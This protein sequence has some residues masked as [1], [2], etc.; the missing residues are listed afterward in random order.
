LALAEQARGQAAEAKALRERFTK[1]A[2][3]SSKDDPKRTN[4]DR[5]TWLD[6]LEL[7]LLLKE[8]DARLAAPDK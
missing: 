2:A 8:L 3:E 5:L 7:D 6:R 1:W 4:R